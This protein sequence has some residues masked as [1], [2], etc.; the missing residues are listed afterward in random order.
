MRESRSGELVRGV[1]VGMWRMVGGSGA[2]KQTR[3][4]KDIVDMIPGRVRGTRTRT[5]TRKRVSRKER[6]DSY[7][8]SCAHEAVYVDGESGTLLWL[9]LWLLC[10]GHDGD[11]LGWVLLVVDGSVVG[12]P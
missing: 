4:T 11:I 2:L 6:I 1:V 7:R 8:V 9:L 12:D 10:A 5:R 3:R